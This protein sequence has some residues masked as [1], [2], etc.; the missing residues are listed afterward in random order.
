VVADFR[1]IAIGGGGVSRVQAQSIPRAASPRPRMRAITC[2]MLLDDVAA[3]FPGLNIIMA[4][5]AVPWVDSA[6]S[7][8]THKANVHIDLSGWSPKYFPPQLVRAVNSFLKD[9]VL[10]GSD[11]PVLTPDLWLKAFNE[12]EI[13]AEVRPGILKDN[14]ISTAEPLCGMNRIAATRRS[15]ALIGSSPTS[16]GRSG[17]ARVLRT[18]AADADHQFHASQTEKMSRE[19]SG[20]GG[21]P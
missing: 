11:F 14:A 13:E 18:S 7:I 17:S 2:P 3:D 6:I 16:T 4:H 8:A 15:V 1:T 21:R 9:K 12:L 19:A 5:A 20:G 10:F